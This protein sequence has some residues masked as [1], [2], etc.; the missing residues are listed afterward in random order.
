MKLLTYVYLLS[1]VS[2]VVVPSKRDLNRGKVLKLPFKKTHNDSSSVVTSD[3]RV[4]VKRES[5]KE[6]AITNQKTFYS[7]DL[8][9]GTP[10]QD[11]TV[12]L[13][14][15][16][17]DLWVTGYNNPY[18]LSTSKITSPVNESVSKSSSGSIDCAKYGTFNKGESSTYHDN[19]TSFS[20]TYGDQSFASGTWGQDVLSLDGVDISGVS[21]AVADNTDSNVGVLGIGFEALETTT[22]ISGTVSDPHTYPNLPVVLKSSGAIDSIAYSLYLDDASAMEGSILFGGIDSSKYT[23]TLYTVPI[24][25]IYEGFSE[26]IALDITLQGLGI[27]SSSVKETITTSSI[28]VLLDSGTT[29]TYFPK[30]YVSLV[31]NAI[32]ASYVSSGLYGMTCPSDDDDRQLVFDF[33]GFHIE[34]PLSSFLITSSSG[35][36]ICFLGM[37]VR[38][39][40]PAILGDLFLTHA[41]VVYDL[42]NYEISMA[43]ASYVDSEEDIEAILSSVPGAVKAPGYSNTWNGNQVYTSGGNIFTLNNDDT[44]SVT[45]T[46]SASNASPTVTTSSFVASTS[47]T[48]QCNGADFFDNIL[49]LLDSVL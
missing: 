36:N 32:G 26:P 43:Q 9:I 27:S 6:F 2:A 34:A 21:F 12:L 38:D 37:V 13:D 5:S 30:S 23:G 4:L 10:S 49:C 1:T 19:T 29:L 39:D 24:V 25:N 16:S 31:A 40:L 42:D 35:S 48:A 3:G 7:V 44:A 15:G 22:G 46:T 20:I 17:S 11:V 28:P 14:T 47:A 8:S 33:G 18:C 45:T 41:Y